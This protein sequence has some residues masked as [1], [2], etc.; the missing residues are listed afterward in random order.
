MSRRSGRLQLSVDWVRIRVREAVE[1]LLVDGHQQTVISRRQLRL[2]HRE[3]R[4]KVADVVRRHLD[5]PTGRQDV[6]GQTLR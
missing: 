2:L 5:T 4:V 6:V 1:D 3:V